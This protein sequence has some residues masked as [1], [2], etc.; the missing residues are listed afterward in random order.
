MLSKSTKKFLKTQNS[1]VIKVRGNGNQVEITPF[2]KH[3]TQTHHQFGTRIK[4]HKLIILETEL[5]RQIE[6]KRI[7]L[8]SN[9]T[10][11]LNDCI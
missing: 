10:T 1:A 3:L 6:I 7:E 11:W 4:F 8:E 2:Q 9:W 5:M